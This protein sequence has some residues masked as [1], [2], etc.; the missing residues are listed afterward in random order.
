MKRAP[1]PQ[2]FDEVFDETSHQAPASNVLRALKAPMVQKRVLCATDL[3]PRSLPA[4]I[5]ASNT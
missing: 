2:E 1:R 5:R 4:M 3:S